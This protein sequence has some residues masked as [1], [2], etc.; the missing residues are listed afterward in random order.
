MKN[1]PGVYTVRGLSNRSHGLPNRKLVNRTFVV[2][3]VTHGLDS[4]ILDPLDKE[5]FSPLK[6][7]ALVYSEGDYCIDYINT[8]RE[9]G[10][11]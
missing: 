9:G 2:A 3:G 1:F 7:A 4:V 10:F 6:T 8:F 5:L 11:D